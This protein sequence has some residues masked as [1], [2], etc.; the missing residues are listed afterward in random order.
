MTLE[1]QFLLF[2]LL[3]LLSIDFEGAD[4]FSN[5]VEIENSIAEAF[6]TKELTDNSETGKITIDILRFR[7][8]L[9]KNGLIEHEK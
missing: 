8:N 1:H 6:N 5:S 9:I 7:Y 3:F 4:L 2:R